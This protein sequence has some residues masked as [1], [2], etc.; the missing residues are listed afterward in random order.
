MF[1]VWGGIAGAQSSLELLVGEGVVGGRIDLRAVGELFAGAAAR[2]FALR[3]KGLL[4]PGA[5]AD[6]V[7]VDVG[8]TRVLAAQDLRTRHAIS[9]YVGRE[10]RAR[11]VRTIVRGSTVYLKGD[12]VAPPGGRLSRP[13]PARS[14]EARS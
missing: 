4:E 8:A 9:P 2:R 6:L 11:V 5:D 3:G 12:M 10:L 1:A 13:L 7:L 14:T